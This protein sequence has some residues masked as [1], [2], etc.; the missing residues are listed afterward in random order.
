[1]ANPFDNQGAYAIL[2]K[3]SNLGEKLGDATADDVLYL[4]RRVKKMR[5]KIVELR[6]VIDVIYDV[7]YCGRGIEEVARRYIEGQREKE[8]KVRER[9]NVLKKRGRAV[10]AGKSDADQL[11]DQSFK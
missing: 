7:K 10:V 8:R 5:Q 1:M 3:E 9:V 6:D 2:N 11:G 4:A